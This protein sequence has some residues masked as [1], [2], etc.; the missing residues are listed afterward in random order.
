MR[1][2]QGHAYLMP[3]KY[4]EGPLEAAKLYEDDRPLGPAN[5]LQQDI[6][7][8]GAGRYWLYRDSQTYFG[9]ALMFSTSDNT[10]PN[11]NGRKY[12]LK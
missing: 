3:V 1:L 7:A 8:K 4:F 6:I 11:T 10:D 5:T 2:Y 12:Y 9:P